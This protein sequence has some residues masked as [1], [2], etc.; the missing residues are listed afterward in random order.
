MCGPPLAT[1]IED[2]ALAAALAS[3]AFT[4]GGDE[5][6]I[7]RGV[8]PGL[9]PVGATCQLVPSHCDPTVNLHDALVGVRDGRVEAL[10]EIDARGPG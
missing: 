4:S 7:L 5:H 2:A 9:L 6:G 8:A 10:F 1:S 3:A